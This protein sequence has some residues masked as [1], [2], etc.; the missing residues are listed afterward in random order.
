MIDLHCHILPG[1]DDGSPNLETSLAMARMALEDGITQMACTP[2]I[3]PGMYEN[4]AKA[5]AEATKQLQE[6]LNLAGIPLKLTYA[7]D[8]HVVPDL[9]KKLKNGDVPTFNA[10]KYFLL[11]PP[12]HVAPPN[13][14]GFVF[15]VMA[16]GYIPIVTHPERLS[17]ML[18]SN[19]WRYAG[20]GCS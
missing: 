15:E 5:I 3:Y 18:L 8:T 7:S 19:I 6:S 16:A 1:I 20:L 9:V 4:N 10:G 17:I 13:F 12:H 2:H 11:E 14:E